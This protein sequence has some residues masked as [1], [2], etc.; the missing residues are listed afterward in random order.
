MNRYEL[1]YII[2]TALEENAPQELIEGFS[3]LI[4]QNGE[5]ERWTDTGQAPSG[6][7]HQRQAPRA[8]YVL[9][10]FGPRRNSPARSRRNMGISEDVLRYLIIKLEGTASS[11]APCVP[12]WR[13]WLPRLRRRR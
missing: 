4:K 7:C 5:V 12:A 2:D 1:T 3:A 9:V 13:P 6:L 11:R 10:T 8:Y